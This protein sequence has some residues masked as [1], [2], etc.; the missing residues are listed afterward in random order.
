M[1][2]WFNWPGDQDPTVQAHIWSV[3]LRWVIFKP[4]LASLPLSYQCL[5]QPEVPLSITSSIFFSVSRIYPIQYNT[6]IYSNVGVFQ[7]L[8]CFYHSYCYI[9][10]TLTLLGMHFPLLMLLCPELFPAFHILGLLLYSFILCFRILWQ[11]MNQLPI[12]PFIPLGFT[13]LYYTIFILCHIYTLH[14]YFPG[15]CLPVC[16]LFWGIGPASQMFAMFNCVIWPLLFSIL[17]Y[18][19]L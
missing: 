2:P 6:R 7:A 1:K 9:I 8:A 13:Y 10:I 15:M 17:I 11:A 4:W 19:V 12:L 14:I 18:S 5:W 3:D 16:H